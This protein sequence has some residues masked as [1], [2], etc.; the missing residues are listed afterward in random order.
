MHASAMH[1]R[2]VRPLR[3]LAL[4]LA[5]LLVLP[6]VAVAQTA[7]AV[8]DG[9]LA[10]ARQQ[11][12]GAEDYTLVTDAFT[13]YARKTAD[14]SYETALRAPD[15]GKLG[16]GAMMQSAM[17]QGVMQTN[18]PAGNADMAKRDP[19]TIRQAFA[20]GMEVVGTE[21]VNG[22][23]AVVLRVADLA[24]LETLGQQQGMDPQQRQQME[25]SMK[26][27]R[28]YV[29]AARYVP[30]RTYMEVEM[31]N[32]SGGSGFPMTM[33][34]DYLDYQ[35]TKGILFA[36]EIRARMGMP[37][38]ALDAM[39]EDADEQERAMVRS[40]MDSM[41]RDQR[42]TVTEVRVNTGLDDSLFQEN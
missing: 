15:G 34:M 5:A 8:A 35:E 6:A 9:L 20:D 31:P 12:Q 26:E 4:A 39:L 22:T 11:T 18:G 17:V 41:M 3:L 33:Q 1:A 30:V 40:M 42:L 38:E 21:S 28:M 32:P 2:S 27:M 13:L 37:D 14:G 16:I 7:A 23:Q 29:D 25:E 10:R 24:A 36:R 19:S